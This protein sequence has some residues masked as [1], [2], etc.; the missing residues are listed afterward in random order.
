[1]RRRY[2]RLTTTGDSAPQA[3]PPK[4]TYLSRR[5]DQVIHKIYVALAGGP[6][7][8]MPAARGHH[9]TAP[10]VG[11]GVDVAVVLTARGS[12]PSW[13]RR[14]WSCGTASSTARHATWTASSATNIGATRR[15]RGGEFDKGAVPASSRWRAVAVPSVVAAAVCRGAGL[16]ARRGSVPGVVPPVA[17]V[18]G[19]GSYDHGPEGLGK[20]GRHQRFDQEEA[21]DAPV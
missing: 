19:L 2:A 20:W 11:S 4:L 5:H 7:A 16:E 8:A 10:P 12:W 17:W 1:M 14:S 6:S 9:A 21:G 18:F 15:A 13:L 3:A